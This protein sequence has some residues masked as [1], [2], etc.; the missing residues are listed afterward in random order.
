MNWFCVNEDEQSE[1]MEFHNWEFL[2]KSSIRMKNE[3]D[4]ILAIRAVIKKVL[5]NEI[6]KTE[7]P[8]YQKP[9]SPKELF[10]LVRRGFRTG[11]I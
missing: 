2:R 5:K 11:L 1:I 10:G 8:Q 7:L 9:G 6:R 4:E 3:L